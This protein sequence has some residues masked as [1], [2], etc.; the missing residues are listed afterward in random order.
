MKPNWTTSPSRRWVSLGNPTR[1]AAFVDF[2]GV[3]LIVSVVLRTDLSPEEPRPLRVQER[4]P[5]SNRT[6]CKAC[7]YKRCVSVGMSPL[8]SRFGR[9][10]KY[11]KVSMSSSQKPVPPLPVLPPVSPFP[12]TSPV[13]YPFLF[14]SLLHFYAFYRHDVPGNI[15]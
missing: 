14:S 5:G 13:I 6:S 7:R 8:N 3:Q 2:I 15:L 11:F 4:G 9:R 1:L 10:S 12:L